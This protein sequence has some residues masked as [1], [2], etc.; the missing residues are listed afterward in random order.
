MSPR[1]RIATSAAGPPIGANTAPI[2]PS[3][4]SVA[5]AG[6]PV[7]PAIACHG[8]RYDDQSSPSPPTGSSLP[9]KRSRPSRARLT[10]S[11]SAVITTSSTTGGAKIVAPSTRRRLTSTKTSSGS[12]SGAST[13]SSVTSTGSAAAVSGSAT[14]TSVPG[15]RSPDPRELT[16]RSAPAG[17]A[18][19]PTGRVSRASS[20]SGVTHADS[21]STV[22]GTVPSATSFSTP[23]RTRPTTPARAA[24]RSRVQR[25]VKSPRTVP[26]RGFRRR[27]A[28][29]ARNPPRPLRRYVA[30]ANS[31]RASPVRRSRTNASARS[32]ESSGSRIIPSQK[33]N[34]EQFTRNTRSP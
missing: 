13:A 8:A 1:S 31:A 14:A 3:T 18:S 7:P 24:L 34:G 33:E 5:D 23:R 11:P 2:V 20:A 26:G 25:P 29:A 19:G 10:N 4:G 16:P 21:V 28:R 32:T 27:R 12:G 6:A 9:P 22:S 30:A 17:S 15:R